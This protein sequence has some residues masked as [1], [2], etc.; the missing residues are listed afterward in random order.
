MTYISHSFY[1]KKNVEMRQKKLFTTKHR[2]QQFYLSPENFKPALLV[3][4]LAFRISVLLLVSQQ[5]I[6]RKSVT[7]TEIWAIY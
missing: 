7:G 1:P 2:I 5:F 6:C 3:A 4:L